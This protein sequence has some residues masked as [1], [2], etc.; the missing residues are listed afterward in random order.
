[1]ILPEGKALPWLEEA[2]IWRD[3]EHLQSRTNQGGVTQTGDPGLGLGGGGEAPEGGDMCIPMA[4]S[5]YTTETNTT[6]IKQLSS[7]EKSV[8]VKIIKYN[9]SNRRI[10]LAMQGTKVQSLVREL[11][12][13]VQWGN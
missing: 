1:M 8:N 11:R 3:Q 5:H 4:D 2:S 10:H 13:H 12:S 6:F 9:S 7:N